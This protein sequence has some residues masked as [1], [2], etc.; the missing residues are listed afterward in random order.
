[1][2]KQLSWSN[3]SRK[4]CSGDDNGD[5]VGD[6]RHVLNLG[7]DVQRV[8]ARQTSEMIPVTL[9]FFIPFPGI[10]LGTA[11]TKKG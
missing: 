4:L 9:D 1:M 11:N 5:G 6:G 2:R 10:G 3:E 7:I 8:E